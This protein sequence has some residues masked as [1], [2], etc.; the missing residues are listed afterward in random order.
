MAT[1]V[2]TREY[3][4]VDAVAGIVAI[5]FGLAAILWPRITLGV[6]IA[7]FGVY[8][9]IDG[10][11]AIVHMFRQIRSRQTWWPSLL[12][13][14]VGIAAGLFVLANPFVSA[15]VLLY[16]IA[17]W[18]I[19]VGIVEV[20]AGLFGAQFMVLVVG[21]LSIVFGFILLGNPIAGALA[22]VLVIGVFAIIRGVLLLI[23]ATRAPSL[24]TAG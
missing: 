13:G 15:V 5:L 19:L 9:L 24:P 23:Q 2:P 21:I 6:L 22:L 4:W 1:M 16:A 20:V 14:I 10:A 12:I 3:W 7:L 18:A 11:L 17:F 8:A